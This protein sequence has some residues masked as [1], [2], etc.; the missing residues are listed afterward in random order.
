MEAAMEKM[1][2]SDRFITAMFL[3]KEYGKLLKLKMNKIV[4]FI[5]CLIL[6]V[7]TIQFAIPNLA[8]IAGMGGIKNIVLNVVPDFS[9]K[10]GVFYYDEK[11][12]QK[13]EE[14]QMYVLIDTSVEEFTKE[15]VP[16]NM[17]QAILVSKSNMLV[18]NSMGGLGTFQES[19]FSD[20]KG[21]TVTNQSV[22]NMAPFIYATLL[23]FFGIAYIFTMGKYLFMAIIYA[24]MVF[25]L[26]EHF[27]GNLRSKR[28]IRLHCSPRQ[29]VL[30]SRLCLF[31]SV[32]SCSLWQ[33][34]HLI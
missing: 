14:M 34:L 3:P 26:F 20:L 18:F 25:F 33:V 1:K 31:V 6:L 2:L 9:L 8:A 4:S 24:G 5:V 28:L 13:D 12:E 22:A 21:I 7:T 19:K 10:D 29:S 11:L 32:Q 16:D 27:C 23:F 30:L 17:I 15:D